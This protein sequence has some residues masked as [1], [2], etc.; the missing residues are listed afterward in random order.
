MIVYQKKNDMFNVCGKVVRLLSSSPFLEVGWRGGGVNFF[1]YDLKK[2]I[3]KFSG[4]GFR[5]YFLALFCV[6]FSSVVVLQVSPED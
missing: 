6:S 1:K 5:K 4:Q 2:K 3:L